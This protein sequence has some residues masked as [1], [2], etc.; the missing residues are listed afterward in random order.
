MTKILKVIKPFFVMEN[1]DTFEYNADTDQYESVYNEE[2]NSSNEDNS[3]V[4]SSYNSVYRISKE[5]A[6]MLLDNGY[7]EEVDD[8]KRFVN[9]FDE[10]NN[11]LSEYNNELCV[12]KSKADENTPQCL[13]VEKETV[14]RNMIKLLEYLKGLKK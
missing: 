14:L 9:I 1:G 3:T 4:V 8:K 7:V 5:Y 2:H 10:I 12:L 6:K 11:K 13:L